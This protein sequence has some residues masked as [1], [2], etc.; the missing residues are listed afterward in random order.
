[1]IGCK[2]IHREDSTKFDLN[3]TFDIQDFHSTL[4]TNKH[5]HSSDIDTNNNA[6]N[7]NPYDLQPTLETL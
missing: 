3:N 5:K 1:M 2:G 4:L 7:Y 6:D